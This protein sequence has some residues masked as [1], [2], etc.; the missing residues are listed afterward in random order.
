MANVISRWIEDRLG[1]VFQKFEDDFAYMTQDGYLLCQLLKSYGIITKEDLSHIKSPENA[2]KCL[3]NF[4]LIA[5][6]LEKIDVGLNDDEICE[7]VNVNGMTSLNLFFKVYLALHDKTGIDFAAQKIFGGTYSPDKTLKFIVDKVP[8][9]NSHLFKSKRNSILEDN[10]DVIQW[11]RDRLEMMLTKC[12]SARE[13]YVHVVKN[14]E[15]RKSS[16]SWEFQLHD[17]PESKK[18]EE[19]TSLMESGDFTYKQQYPSEKSRIKNL[20]MAS[21]NPEKNKNIM[22]EIQNKHKTQQAAEILK[23]ELQKEI[24]WTLWQKVKDEEIADFDKNIVDTL[25]KQSFYEKQMLCKVR[26][27]KIHKETIMEGKQIIADK[28]N[29]EKEREFIDN[30]FGFDSKAKVEEYQYYFEKERSLEL[31]RSIYEKKLRLRQERCY[32]MC[33]KIV[34]DICHYAINESE[35]V[36]YYGEPP[37]K[38]TV[39]SWKQLF[40]SEISME[41]SPVT[42]EELVQITEDEDIESI[43]Q[44]EL[45]RQEKID[46]QDFENYVHF[47]PPWDLETTDL[48]ESVLDEMKCGLNIIGSI[49]QRILETKYPLPPIP[50]EPDL[51]KMEIAV[52]INGLY[53]FSCIPILRKMLKHKNYEVFEMQDVI[54]FCINAYKDEMTVDIVETYDSTES[55]SIISHKVKKGF[56]SKLKT[57]TEQHIP[58]NEGNHKVIGDK[59]EKKVQTPKYFPCEEIVFTHQ[60]EL[61]KIAEEEL[62]RGKILTDFLLIAMFVEY[63][64]SKINNKG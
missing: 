42:P 40:V 16:F 7:I 64:K 3:S 5:H 13:D 48:D 57:A 4:N 43:I 23:R 11:H 62:T 56:K 30:V 50:Q 2:E 25:L 60:A 63:L 32:K 35:Y 59:A 6:W 45:E 61:G 37:R 41:D 31:H 18:G 51:P 14:R 28:I 24:L 15:R 39:N 29:K 58:G 47:E 26:E 44:S 27:V 20:G 8:E 12:K 36:S 54:N 46:K 53:H 10:F 19:N 34:E 52:C 49:V 38:S 17:V 9:D 33:S 1:I 21:G 22:K 55:R